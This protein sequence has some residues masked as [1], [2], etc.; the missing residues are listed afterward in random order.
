MHLATTKHWCN[1]CESENGKVLLFI[2]KIKVIISMYAYMSIFE[3]LLIINGKCLKF[4]I[5]ECVW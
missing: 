3:A 1:E 2:L 5:R 4:V